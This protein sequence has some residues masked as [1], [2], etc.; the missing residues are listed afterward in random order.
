MLLAVKRAE[1]V[2]ER[3]T[4]LSTTPPPPVAHS[5]TIH[6]ASRSSSETSNLGYNI[7]PEDCDGDEVGDDDRVLEESLRALKLKPTEDTVPAGN[8]DH[9]GAALLAFFNA[10]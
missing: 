4:P 9:L 2:P 10:L 3:Q 5:S 7:G 6:Q 8:L 1:L